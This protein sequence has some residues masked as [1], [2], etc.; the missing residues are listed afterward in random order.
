MRVV[1][2]FPPKA[3]ATYVPLG[4]AALAPYIEQHVKDA[5]V[6]L[7]DLNIGTWLRIAGQD[8]SGQSLMDFL[9]GRT[10]NFLDP[11][12]T[13]YHKTDWD[14][15]RNEMNRLCD[16]AGRYVSTDEADIA[17]LMTLADL[18]E[19][20][21]AFDPQI[22]GFSVLFPEQLPFAAALCKSVRQALNNGR[23]GIRR[24]ECR[25][26]MGGAMM[27][28]LSVSDLMTT[29]PEIDAVVRG[30]GEAAA[31]ALCADKEWSTI[32]GLVYRAG[33]QIV[34]NPGSDL[35]S[36][37]ELPAPDFSRLPI[38]AYFNPVP[39]L[40]VL[41][42]RGCAW[43]RCRFCSHNFSFGGYRR[44]GIQDF[45]SE[46]ARYN[47]ELGARHFYSADE[48]I[49]PEDMDAICTE[50]MARGLNVN[51]HVLGRPT[52]DYTA[53]RLALWSVAG[54]RWIGWG[55]ESGSQRLLNLINKGTRTPEIRQVL[56]NAAEAGISN[57]ALMIF[58]LPTSTDEDLTE[59][60]DFLESVY[61]TLDALTASAFVLFDGTHFARNARRYGL[62]IVG[63][64]TVIHRNGSGV[65]ARRLKF[66]E[67]SLD[68]SL[69]SPRGTLE[70][71]SWRRYRRWLGDPPLLEQ[72]TSEHCLIHISSGTSRRGHLTSSSLDSETAEV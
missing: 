43:R 27:S 30:E 57:L 62:H 24:S 7:L 16:Q 53:S 34:T 65:N 63:P 42:S 67:I 70:V 2:V 9:Q 41:Y 38:P 28:A 68:G 46:L 22:V 12:E 66:R 33:R 15:L 5:S 51:L 52:P 19:Q 36:L 47:R 26:V 69:R 21:M 13:L 3:S 10:G 4:I 49:P 32:P 56:E 1:L 37:T 54:C 71:S 8:P 14:R 35:I 45:V 60:L 17:F 31:A 48:F 20:I 64:E 55:V 40:P 59:T 44:K 11:G 18:T 39:V 29:L 50:I 61:G 25:I 72:M 6:R 23:T 58:G